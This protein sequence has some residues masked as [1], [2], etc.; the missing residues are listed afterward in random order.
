MANVERTH[1]G[2]AAGVKNQMLLQ[3]NE[4]LIRRMLRVH[5][6]F[7]RAATLEEALQRCAW[8]DSP[9]LKPAEVPNALESV[10]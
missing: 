3:D 6:E 4:V 1:K 10:A 5:E 9:T 7:E 8:A 2:V